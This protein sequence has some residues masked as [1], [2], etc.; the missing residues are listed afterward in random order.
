MGWLL[1]IGSKKAGFSEDAGFLAG[2][3]LAPC[4]ML[5]LEPG[6]FQV[7]LLKHVNNTVDV[8]PLLKQK[9]LW[10]AQTHVC[11]HWEDLVIEPTEGG[12]RLRR[13][14][15]GAFFKR[16]CATFSKVLFLICAQH[17]VLVSLQE[18][19]QPPSRHLEV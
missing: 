18:M 3:V 12:P 15:R 8:D 6:T 11:T 13:M 4:D 9:C 7:E 5:P 16:S 10:K 1:D 2:I 17:N 19:D 14:H